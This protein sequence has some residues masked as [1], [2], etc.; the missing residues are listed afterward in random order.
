MNRVAVANH[1]FGVERL[2]KGDSG[3]K[4]MKFFGRIKRSYASLLF[5]QLKESCP[6]T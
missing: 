5:G 6:R 1:P 2:C 3:R 4:E